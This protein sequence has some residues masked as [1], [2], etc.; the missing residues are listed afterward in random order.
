MELTPFGDVT[1]WSGKSRCASCGGN[2]KPE[3]DN[4]FEVDDVFEM[5]K[6][7]IDVVN[8]FAMVKRMVVGIGSV[9]RDEAQKRKIA[10]VR[11]CEKCGLFSY[12]C[13]KCR[14][15]S[16]SPGRPALLGSIKTICPHCKQNLDLNL[17]GLR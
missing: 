15:L 5:G 9:I 2:L 4:S 7:V 17:Y 8:P 6:A 10:V 13:P 11:Q 3:G 1:R 16:L 14:R 12:K